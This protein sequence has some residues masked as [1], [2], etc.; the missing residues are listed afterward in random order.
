MGKVIEMRRSSDE[1]IRGAVLKTSTC[2]R[3]ERPLNKLYP[4]EIRK[5]EANHG[6]EPQ[7]LG[8]HPP[9]RETTANTNLHGHEIGTLEQ[10]SDERTNADSNLFSEGRQPDEWQ[11]VRQPEGNQ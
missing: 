9:N 8:G 3:L 11:R 10:S 5:P 2:Q 1:Q 7:T 6:E 4:L